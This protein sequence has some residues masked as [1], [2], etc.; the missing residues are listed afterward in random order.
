M[1]FFV[2]CLAKKMSKFRHVCGIV[3]LWKWS[4]WT[5]LCKK[6]VWT[7]GSAATHLLGTALWAVTV[8]F[9]YSCTKV[10]RV[11]LAPWF[12]RWWVL[13]TKTKPC[14]TF[15]WARETFL[16]GGHMTQGEGKSFLV[17]ILGNDSSPLSPVNLM[18]SLGKI[19]AAATT[20]TRR[21]VLKMKQKWRMMTGLMQ[22]GRAMMT[23]FGI[24]Q[25]PQLVKK[26]KTFFPPPG[27]YASSLCP[28]DSPRA[29][30]HT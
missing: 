1:R 3:E 11:G 14:V 25:K 12:L 24:L 20:V 4:F 29:A 26:D 21:R 18:L 15:A 5:C 10:L 19:W 13:L 30:L 27:N 7:V 28:C 16:R 9:A 6:W 8:T 17:T 22:R 23:L 2:A